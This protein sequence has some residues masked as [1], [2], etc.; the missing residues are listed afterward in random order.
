MMYNLLFSKILDDDIESC[1][2]Y[3]RDALEAP[4]AA[5]NLMRELYEKL[6]YIKGKPYSRPLV[7]DKLLAS[8]GI[9]SVKVKNYLLFYNI[10]EDKIKGGRKNIN[11]ITFMYSK[12]DWVSILRKTPLDEIM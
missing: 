10:E 3:I 9:R 11:I 5:E 1:Y 4:T 8:F 2:I 12:R 6:E 7:H